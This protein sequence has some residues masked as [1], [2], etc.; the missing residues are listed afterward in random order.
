MSKICRI[1]KGWGIQFQQTGKSYAAF[2]VRIA[3]A[4]GPHVWLPQVARKGRSPQKGKKDG[5]NTTKQTHYKMQKKETR[6]KPK[7]HIL[8]EVAV[9]AYQCI[10]SPWPSPALRPI[11]HPTLSLASC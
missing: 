10:Q 5:S 7:K 4:S 8:D 2:A 6:Q 9:A 1:A 3:G 11:C